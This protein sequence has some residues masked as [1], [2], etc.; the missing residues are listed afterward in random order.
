MGA[1]L[2][3]FIIDSRVRGIGNSYNVFKYPL[4][5]N[6]IL[7]GPYGSAIQVRNVTP[8][9]EVTRRHILA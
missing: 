8:Q 2:V 4:K 9:T 3:C 1:L 7:Y 5:N 6:T